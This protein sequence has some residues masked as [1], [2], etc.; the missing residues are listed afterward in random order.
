MRFSIRAISS[1]I[2]T[3]FFVA[4]LLPA[5]TTAQVAGQNVNMVSGTKWPTGDPFLQR[6]NEPSMAVS[7]RNPMHLLSGANDY[8][9]VDLETVLSGGAETGALAGFVQ[10]VRRRIHLAEQSVAGV[11]LRRLAV[12][13]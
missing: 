8:R 13:G 7:T 11:P 5:P 6:Q 3:A 9:S 1:G 12:Y 2:A 4:L 10:V